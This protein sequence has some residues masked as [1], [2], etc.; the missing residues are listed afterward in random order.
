[1]SRNAIVFS[2]FLDLEKSESKIRMSNKNNPYFL[3]NFTIQRY[4]GGD[5][6]AYSYIEVIKEIL[7]EIKSFRR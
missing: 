5:Y 1:M 2:F 3:E 7:S 4:R 6:H